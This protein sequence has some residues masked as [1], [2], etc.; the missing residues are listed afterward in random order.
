MRG[1]R[2]RFS[3]FSN[4]GEEGEEYIE[5]A[6]NNITLEYEYEKDHVVTYR[7]RW[8]FTVD[9]SAIGRSVTVL[10]FDEPESNKTRSSFRVKD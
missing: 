10:V 1:T 7:E 2:N 9:E 8:N 4:L 5:D 3:T 6:G